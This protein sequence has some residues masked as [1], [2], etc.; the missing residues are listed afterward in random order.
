MTDTVPAHV[1]NITGIMQ[2]RASKMN[3]SALY[4]DTSVVTLTSMSNYPSL[5]DIYI[6][7]S[8]EH[9]AVEYLNSDVAV[10]GEVNLHVPSTLTDINI[11]H[12]KSAV[13]IITEE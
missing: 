1:L 6:G 9:L 13:N 12:N 11:K 10:P 8:T 4:A 7:Q 5:T 2:F 3:I